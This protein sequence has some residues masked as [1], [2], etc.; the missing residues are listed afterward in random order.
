MRTTPRVLR[1]SLVAAG[2]ATAI[3][4]S[5]TG[6]FPEPGPSHTSAIASLSD[7]VRGTVKHLPTTLG[8][9]TP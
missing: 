7:A 9:P 2:L 4:L 1:A 3:G 8:I 6:A 5:L